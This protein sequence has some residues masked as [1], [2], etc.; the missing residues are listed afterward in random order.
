[1]TEKK[2]GLI[3]DKETIYEF[4]LCP[5]SE[6]SKD[7]Y[8][9]VE[10]VISIV[11]HKHFGSFEFKDSAL[12][13]VIPQL[14][15]KR[16]SYD[17]DRDAYNY[18]YTMC[19]NLIGNQLRKDGRID[20]LHQSLDVTFMSPIDGDDTGFDLEDNGSIPS[21]IPLAV[22]K[23]FKFLTCEE[24]FTVKRVSREDS[25][26]LLMFIETNSNNNKFKPVVLSKKEY[27][28]MF[29]VLTKMF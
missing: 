9:E 28:A 22:E 19:R 12:S 23:Y 10:K 14:L 13:I 4:L 3:V 1:M 24:D 26:A 21:E 29:R 2:G 15:I 7:H 27:N 16:S 17:P 8:K 25:L 18:M 5:I 20:G 11:K 6:I